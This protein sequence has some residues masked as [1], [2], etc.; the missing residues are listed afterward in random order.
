M[1]G[2]LGK[3]RIVILACGALDCFA[4]GTAYLFGVFQP[5]IMQ[6][7]GIDSA[8]ATT[9]YTLV[10]MFMTI[11]QFIAGPM[12]K[13][14]GVKATVSVGLA[15]M[16]LGLFGCSLLPP[17]MSQMLL[18][19]YTVVHGLGIGI[20]YNTVA[21]TTVRW[22]PDHKGLA[23]SISLGMMGGAGVLLAPVFGFLLQAFG[24][25]L[26]YRFLALLFVPCILFSLAVFRDT[27]PGY[28]A[29][30]KPTGVVARQTAVNECNGLRDLIRCRDAWML[31]LLY[32]SLVPTFVIA[33]GVFVSFGTQAKTI[34]P[35]VAVWFVSIGAIVQVIGRFVVPSI[36]DRVGRKAVFVAVLAIMACST[37]MV[38]GLNGLPYAIAYCLLSFSYGGGVTAMPSIIADRLGSR[39]ATQNIAFAEIGTLLGSVASAILVNIASTAP[40]IV[41]SGVLSILLGA[42]S[43][44]MIYKRK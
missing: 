26:S 41:I 24:L 7:F 43:L 11:A 42:F 30:Y 27:P 36:S 22:F 13:R 6:H 17:S 14:I 20:A 18:V 4:V 25:Q 31:V 44:A 12:Q 39:N 40:A 15:L 33:S 19:L 29:D 28:M 5:Y 38:V 8:S 1:N 9:P 34:S 21:A 23:T 16:A 37:A 2:S 32:F 10:W 3:T 35:D